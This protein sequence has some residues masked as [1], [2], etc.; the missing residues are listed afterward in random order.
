MNLFPED[1][2]T[3]S[4]V[5]HI[6]LANPETYTDGKYEKS[7]DL[8]NGTYRILFVP[9]GDSPE[10]LSVAIKGDSFS[11]VQ[12]FKL[13]GIPHK[14]EFSEYYTWNYEGDKTFTISKKNELKIIID[15]NGETTGPVSIDII[16]E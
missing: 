6:T 15:P 7:F 2:E 12:D 14:T 13:V 8:D 16:K 10:I 1:S 5:F 9:N 4:K 11:F 3:S